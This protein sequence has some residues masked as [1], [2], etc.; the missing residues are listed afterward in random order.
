MLAVL[1]EEDHERLRPQMMALDM[2]AGAILHRVGD[3]VVDT[4]FPLAA[5]AAA[6]CVEDIDGES[7]DVAQIGREGAIGGIVSNGHLPA[8][9]TAVVR[10]PGRFIRIKTSALEQAKLHSIALRHW[11]SRYS[12]CLMAQVFQTAVCNG[13]HTI[14]QRTAKLLLA[15]LERTGEP[16]LPVTQE[17]FADMMGVGRS[18]VSRVLGEMR[19][20]GVIESRRKLLLI[21]DEQKLRGLSCGCTM[22]IENHF[23]AVLHGIYPVG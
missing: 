8:Y 16:E 9:S 7:M 15:A 17:Q 1:I 14:R 18:F 2:E 10:F 20:N 23:D 22:L 11:F 4:W 5:A 21:K 13:K 12:D 19:R 3:D 6:F